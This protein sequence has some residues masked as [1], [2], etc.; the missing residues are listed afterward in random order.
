M[1]DK[2]EMEFEMASKELAL[3]EPSGGRRWEF[4]EKIRKLSYDFESSALSFKNSFY[5]YSA[6]T[7][8]KC[9]RVNRWYAEK[10]LQLHKLTMTAQKNPEYD[11]S[12]ENTQ[13]FRGFCMMLTDDISMEYHDWVENNPDYSHHHKSTF[14]QVFPPLPSFVNIIRDCVNII[15]D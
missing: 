5:S 15:R 4:L 10:M 12:F 1:T 14:N 3:E 13:W 7:H 2:L 11:K 6:E 9:L 8:L